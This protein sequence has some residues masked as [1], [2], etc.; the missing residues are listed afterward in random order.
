MKKA[1]IQKL[2]IAMASALV[3]T[4][5]TPATADAAAAMKMNKSS[6]TLYL[7]SD[8]KTETKAKYDFNIS[9][10]PANYSSKY[11]FK[12]YVEDTSI[13]TVNQKGVVTA[14]KVGQTTVKCTITKKSTKKTYK[15][16]KATIT[17]K[18]NAETVTI[19]NAPENNEMN[20]NTTFDF[21][22]TM[23]AANGKAA[24]DKTEWFVTTDEA[25]TEVAD[26]TAATIDSKGVLTAKKPGTYYVIAKTYQSKATKELGYTAVSEAVKVTVKASMTD[27]KNVSMN[28]I[29]ATFDSDM[30]KTLTKDNIVVTNAA[31]VKQSVKS[32]SFSTDGTVATIELWASMTDKV[33]YKVAPADVAPAEFTCGIG[34]VAGIIVTGPEL[35]AANVPTEISY[36]LVDANGVEVTGTALSKVTF[37]T[38]EG[39]AWF[40]GNKV[41]AFQVGK[42]VPV[43]ATYH[44]GTFD[45][46][47]KEITFDS[48]TFNLTCVE[49]VDATVASIT[50]STV[51]TEKL[52]K[53]ADF[54]NANTTLPKND[55]DKYLQV[56]YVN[57]KGETCYTDS[58]TDDKWTFEST[59]TSKLLVDPATGL[60]TPIAEGNVTVI[61]KCGS[62]TQPVVIN[63]VG[64]RKAE[65]ISTDVSSI[66][67][68]AANKAAESKTVKVKL[69]DNFGAE[70]T[71]NTELVTVELLSNSDEVKTN[72][73]KAIQTSVTKDSVTFT[74]NTADESVEGT[75]NY[76]LTKAGKVIVVSVTVKKPTDT[77]AY[78]RVQASATEFDTKVVSGESLK[79]ITFTTNAISTNAMAME[80]LDN[81]NVTYTVKAADGKEIDSKF[82]TV[83][84]KGVSPVVV[85][86][87][88]YAKLAPGKYTV[89]AKVD[90]KDTYLDKTI[91]STEF[92]IKD[93]QTTSGVKVTNKNIEVNKGSDIKAELKAKAFELIEKNTDTTRDFAITSIK[94]S[95]ADVTKE[96]GVQQ[97]YVEKVTVTDT[98]NGNKLNT[99][100]FVGETITVTVK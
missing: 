84:G 11:S 95:T 78:S 86:G 71:A 94:T 1:F 31:G 39:T 10:K 9:N 62:F 74:A 63:V 85:S 25:G 46:T 21:N 19:K 68:S 27:V 34:A 29:Q 14:K 56:K 33:V 17:V 30:S 50:A 69:T 66:V 88:A 58:T 54:A 32:V 67:L 89:S 87:D 23:K 20:V 40:N 61:A 47:G 5:A 45:S 100:V 4:A 93:T 41:T 52:G 6:K 22:R 77:L 80:K 28:K 83:D 70:Y 26:A 48:E 24:T 79:E 76:K 38:T 82:M 75:F 18:A 8:N 55:S 99:E 64:E 15:T 13:A 43:V 44:T 97:V 42:V 65:S 98:I 12:W 36:K 90:S 2:S 91:F 81:V 35:I 73:A 57:S 49:S 92:T 72:A 37:K 3:I 16:V 60:L 59:D 51:T 7:N 96:T 53:N